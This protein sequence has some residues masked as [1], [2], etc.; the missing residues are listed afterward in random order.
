MKTCELCKGSVARP[1]PCG[2]C[3]KKICGCCSWPSA[4]LAPKRFCSQEHLIL[5]LREA[6][7]EV[8]THNR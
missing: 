4:K 2:V 7:H 8:H 3:G 6:G 1:Y 5:A